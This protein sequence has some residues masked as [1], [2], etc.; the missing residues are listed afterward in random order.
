MLKSLN[1]TTL[2]AATLLTVPSSIGLIVL[3]EPM[4]A[5]IYQGGAFQLSDARQTALPDV[6]RI[7]VAEAAHWLN[8]GAASVAV[9]PS[10]DYRIAHPEDAVW[11]IRFYETHGFHSVGPQEK[12]RLLRKY[13]TIPERQIETSVV[14]ADPRWWE[15]QRC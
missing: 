9:M 6:L 4:I 11:A 15:T 3:G 8:E 10:A 2:A 12:D 1:F 14:L 13:W 7:G 5:A